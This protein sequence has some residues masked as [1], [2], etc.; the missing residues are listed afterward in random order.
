MSELIGYGEDYGSWK[1]FVD[2][3][4]MGDCQNIVSHIMSLNLPGVVKKMG[5][6]AMDDD[7][8]DDDYS[9]EPVAAPECGNHHWVEI[10]GHVYEFSKG[11]LK[12]DIDWG[13]DIYD[14][15]VDNRS[16]Y[17]IGPVRGRG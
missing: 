14:P 17:D 1:E 11:T 5:P 12:V 8:Y 3:Q 15:E 9:D 16:R 6:V 7:D 10:D 13:E 2:T 4:G